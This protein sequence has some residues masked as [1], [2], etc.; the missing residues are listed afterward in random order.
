MNI[1][2][3][4]SVIEEISKKKNVINVGCSLHKYTLTK[5]IIQYYNKTRM[6]FAYKRKNDQVAE[7]KKTQKK[8]K[9][10]SKLI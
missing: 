9:T 5:Y 4:F 10:I 8:L 6:I 1:L 7:K 2:Y 3:T